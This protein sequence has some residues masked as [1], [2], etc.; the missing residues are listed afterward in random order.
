MGIRLAIADRIDTLVGYFGVGFVPTGTSDPY[1]LRR[2]ATALAT[3]MD[4]DPTSP[5]LEKL[6]SAAWAAYEHQETKFNKSRQE[7]YESLLSVLSQRL[8]GLLEERCVRYDVRLA[9]LATDIDNVHEAISRALFV[10]KQLGSDVLADA[11]AIATRVGNILR[12][13]EKDGISVQA[14]ASVP[15]G[16]AQPAENELR[17]VLSLAALQTDA[18]A[19]AADWDAAL[20]SISALRVATDTFFDDVRV[21]SE[22]LAER[23]CRLG[24]LRCE[25][26]LLRKLAAFE[27]IVEQ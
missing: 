18:A 7:A 10:Q 1:G 19:K 11:S 3:L 22:D 25:E 17:R 24:L 21:M 6:F 16:D 15:G 26:N 14:G 12:F 8:D 4:A 5:G 13:A 2:A 23:N 9:V 27:L 20:K